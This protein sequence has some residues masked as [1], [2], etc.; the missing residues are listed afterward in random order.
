MKIRATILAS[1]LSLPLLAGTALAADTGNLSLAQAAK[2]GDRDAVRSLLNGPAK[3][4][5][6]GA[7]GTAALIWSADRSDLA[8]VSLLLSAG[9]NVKGADEF[10]ATALYAAAAAD[11][12]LAVMTKLL[13]AGADP[14]A[15]L[16][17]GETALM[18]AARQGNIATVRLL[19]ANNANPNVREKNGGQ[20]ALMWAISERHPEVTDELVLHGADVDTASKKGFTP[21]M[22]AAREGDAK[23]A[24]VLLA[25]GA[26]ANAAM[27]RTAVT[28]LM[29]AS[30]MSHPGTVTALLDYGA[31]PN[32]V[33]VNGL[34]ALHHAV[35]DSDRGVDPE[36]KAA[37]VKTV[38]VLLAHGANPNAQMRPEKKEKPAAPQLAAVTPADGKAP[39][40]NRVGDRDGG[41]VT[42]NG[43]ILQG[44][45]ALVLAAEVNNLDAIKALVDGGADPL[46]PTDRKT[47]A[48][49]LAVGGGTDVL[50]PRSPAERATAVETARFLVE[51]GADVNAAGEFGWTPLHAAA[52]QGLD[53]AIAYLVSKGA[54]PDTKDGFGQTPLSI[55]RSILTKGIGTDR[56]LQIP[57]IYRKDTADLLV[58]LGAASIEKSGVE[59]VLQ[60]HGDE[61]ATQ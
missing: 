35:R 8:M 34:V 38:K 44:A 28:S 20:S 4:D 52:Y 51:H 26:N 47:T 40:G 49:I 32:L 42:T 29:I 10:G 13:A 46:I 17:S 39:V 43:V 55:A 23:S 12:D 41:A 31:N 61:L 11:A 56:R 6:V 37:G 3:R 58:K 14:D 19:L 24:R 60:R 33:D 45:T 54:K 30:A 2:Q 50:R 25:A 1:V 15:R 5:V 59:V 22:F 48:L 21:L 57:R 53:D 16:V 7:E 36:S 9:A 18:A 27:P